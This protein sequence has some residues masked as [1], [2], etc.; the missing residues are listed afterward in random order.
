METFQGFLIPGLKKGI[1]RWYPVISLKIIFF[2]GLPAGTGKGKGYTK[3]D[4]GP[5]P[6]LFPFIPME[7]CLPAAAPFH[8]E[9]RQYYLQSYDIAQDGKNRIRGADRPSPLIL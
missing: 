8:D 3:K 2:I 6:P 7:D 9:K 5:C 4:N 1:L